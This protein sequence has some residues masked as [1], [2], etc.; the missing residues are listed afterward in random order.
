MCNPVQF[1]TFLS[2]GTLI[3]LATSRQ[4]KLYESSEE[5]YCLEVMNCKCQD[6]KANTMGGACRNSYVADLFI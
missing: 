3:R 2:I 5:S 4:I 6:R 1:R